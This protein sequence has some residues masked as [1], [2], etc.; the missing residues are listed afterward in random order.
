MGSLQMRMGL[1]VRQ[2]DVDFEKQAKFFPG[3]LPDTHRSFVRFWRPDL[4]RVGGMWTGHWPEDFEKLG[5]LERQLEVNR[6]HAEALLALDRA[7]VRVIEDAGMKE[8]LR[9]RAIGV[10]SDQEH[11][12]FAE[13]ASC[14]ELEPHYM[15][16][17]PERFIRGLGTIEKVFGRATA[18]GYGFLL[19]AGVRTSADLVK[20]GKRLQDLFDRLASR[21]PVAAK[22]EQAAEVGMGRFAPAKRV[23]LLK[24]IRDQLWQEC[25]RRVG[26]PFLLTQVIDGHLGLRP[27]G[28]GDSLGLAVLDSIIVSKLGLA[29][30]HFV[31]KG[32]FYT[33]IGVSL[34]RFEYWDPMDR[35]GKA[36]VGTAEQVKFVGLFIEGYLRLARGYAMT[37]SYANGV[38]VAGWVLGMW[39]ECAEAHAVLGECL[40]GRQRAR[41]AIEACEKALKLNP[42]LADAHVV[43]GNAYA[44]L[45]RWPQ[46]IACY[47]RAIAKR[48]GYAEAYNN[49]GLALSSSGEKK[50][51]LGA[52]RE[53][54]RV[55]P[56][57]VEAH[58]NLGNL[59]LELDEYDEA[60]AAYREAVERAPRFSGAYYN[61]GQAFYKRGELQQALEAY[62]HAVEANPKHAGA[63]NNIGIVYRDLGEKELAVEALEKAVSLNPML[64]R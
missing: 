43:Q 28:V 26:R 33:A 13:T 29:V 7:G 36:P 37:K 46:A 22:L 11:E 8:A 55:R 51:A 59:H 39:P 58:Y 61:M 40:L 9:W 4:K 34:G 21:A 45:R 48:V 23:G 32:H 5:S 12:H 30:R 63:W 47:K 10:L 6:A 42:N 56:D 16:S 44:M 19:M 64:M 62:Q 54:I 27:G 38:R 53:A 60:I 31:R 57:Y 50:R 35:K 2:V 20:Y 17:N 24:A 41:A 25:P 49:L 14:T 3:D 52:Y 18:L 1:A 15:T